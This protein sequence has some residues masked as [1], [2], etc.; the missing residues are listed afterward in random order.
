MELLVVTILG[1]LGITLVLWFIV[2]APMPEWPDDP[3]EP[4]QN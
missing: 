1:L 4:E 3:T 2:T